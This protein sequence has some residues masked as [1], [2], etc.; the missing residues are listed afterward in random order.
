MPKT[1]PLIE[2]FREMADKMTDKIEDMRA[3]MS[4]NYTPRRHAQHMSKLSDADHLERTQKALYA[5]ADAREAGTLPPVLE[6][7]KSKSAIHEL[8]YTRHANHGYYDVVDT[9]ELTDKSPEGLALADLLG[10]ESD[11]AKARRETERLNAKAKNMI[12]QVPG[13]FPTPPAVVENM[14]D[15]AGVEAGMEVLEPSAG[16]GNIA[17]AIRA[18]G[19]NVDTI[20]INY[21]LVEI[22]ES[23]G[24]TPERAD[25]LTMSP[26]GK[27]Y[28]AVIM[29][30]PFEN[31]Q[32]V[33]HVQHAF[34]FLNDGGVLVSVMA[35]G[36]FFRADCEDFREWLSA[37][38][39]DEDLPEGAFKESGTGVKT[40]LVI[41]HK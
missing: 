6:S 41:L 3:P 32:D 34:E 35:E 9:G 23:K 26:N 18:R 19:A 15:I 36:A 29:N 12:G 38:G 24:F 11:E 28:D 2:K 13:Y 33:K 20:E 27:R 25:F 21:S 31:K 30:P 4:Q 16:S 5:L 17:E 8:L 7:L 1:D 22:L 10:G 14:L 39:Y 37:H 40:R